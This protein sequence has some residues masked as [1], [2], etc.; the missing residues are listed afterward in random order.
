MAGA[1]DDA[2]RR[3]FGNRMSVSYSTSKEAG[4]IPAGQN[5]FTWIFNQ[6][7]NSSLA[8]VLLTPA[9]VRKP[10]VLCEAGA[11][12]DAAIT[13]GKDDSR[14]VRPLVFQLDDSSVPFPF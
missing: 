13:N 3:L 6:V 5:W 14:K 8:I 10:W 9:S 2:V 4:G 1:L 12:V 11:V 7:Q